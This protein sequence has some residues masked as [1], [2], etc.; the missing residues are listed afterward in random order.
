MPTRCRGSSKHLL[1]PS[2]ASRNTAQALQ[3]VLHHQ[4]L[5]NINTPPADQPLSLKRQWDMHAP[6]PFSGDLHAHGG[7]KYAQQTHGN[8]LPARSRVR[9]ITHAD[10]QN[11][12][13]YVLC[14]YPAVQ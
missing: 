4:P 12:S 5:T 14:K 3:A 2:P 6:L 7:K 11:C 10:T 9:R 13:M 8:Q 1:F